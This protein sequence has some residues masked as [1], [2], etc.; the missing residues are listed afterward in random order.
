MLMMNLAITTLV[1]LIHL[2]LTTIQMLT[3]V[4]E[5]VI[6]IPVVLIHLLSILIHQQI[7]T[8]AHVLRL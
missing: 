7:L 6:T 2:H 8:M 4:M 3:I 1:V 5:V